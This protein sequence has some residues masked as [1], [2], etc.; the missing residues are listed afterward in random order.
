MRSSGIDFL[1]ITA[2]EEERDATLSVFPELRRL[3]A[4]QGDIRVYYSGRVLLPTGMDGSYRIVLVSLLDMGR[5]EAATATSDAIRRW[6][7]RYVILV[8]IAGGVFD[9]G[10]ALGDVL[11]PR[12]IVDYEH[13]KIQENS[14]PEVRFRTYT[15]DQRLIGS[16]QAL[17]ATE[18]TDRTSETPRPGLGESKR[19]IG[20]VACGDKVVAKE[21]FLKQSLNGWHRL[22]GV[23]MESSGVAVACMQ[24]AENPGFLM[25]KGVSDL[26]NADKSTSET[27]AW[28]EYACT[29]APHFLRALL[30]SCP[31]PTEP[32]TEV[33]DSNDGGWTIPDEALARVP[34]RIECLFGRK[35]QLEALDREVDSGKRQIAWIGP[36]G[37]GKSSLVRWWLGRRKWRAKYRL[38]AHSFYSQGSRNQGISSRLLLEEWLGE[39]GVETSTDQKDFTLGAEFASKLAG[40]PTI[41]ILD[42][43]EPIQLGGAD[44]ALR[45]NLIDPGIQGLLTTLA[46]HPG[47]NI[48][49]IT[50]RESLTDP[51][52]RESPVFAELSLPPLT[53]EGARELLRH[54]GISGDDIELD[55][56]SRSCSHHAFALTLAAA[57]I[58]TFAMRKAGRF[59]ASQWSL[60]AD[61]E[62]AQNI[63]AWFDGALAQTNEKLMR[64]LLRIL[65]LFDRP[66]GWDALMA[67]RDGYGMDGLNNRLK[68]AGAHE[69]VSA[70]ARLR[71]WHLMHVDLTE[72]EPD[73]DAHPIVREFFGERLKQ[74][75]LDAYRSAHQR[76]WSHFI[77]ISVP[78]P[79]SIRDMGTFIHAIAH[80]CKGRDPATVYFETYHRRMTNNRRSHLRQQL[81]AYT[82]L[83]S[84]LSNFFPNGFLAPME[85][86]PIPPFSRGMLCSD[87]SLLLANLGRL[88]EAIRMKEAAIEFYKGEKKV[89]DMV[90]ARCELV[91]YKVDQGSDL[92]GTHKLS[93]DTLRLSREVPEMG[94]LPTKMDCVLN[95]LW[96]LAYLQYTTG[97]I[98]ESLDIFHL[99]EQMHFEHT[100]E[101]VLISKAGFNYC[102][103]LLDTARTDDDLE[104]VAQRAM[105]MNAVAQENRWADELALGYSIMG[106]AYARKGEFPVSKAFMERAVRCAEESKVDEIRPHVHLA[107]ARVWHGAGYHE[108]ALKELHKA[109]RLARRMAMR[110]LVADCHLLNCTIQLDSEESHPLLAAEKAYIE[111]N[112]I[113]S[114][115]GYNLRQCERL[116]ALARI[117][118]VRGM[119]QEAMK[120]FWECLGVFK[121]R[122][123][124]SL[125]AGLLKVSSSLGVELDLS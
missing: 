91:C 35:G 20:N 108:L 111:A 60:D 76:L 117:Q 82:S 95:A 96:G 68:E 1:F 94:S 81:G 107:F 112:T 59:L 42:G 99:S 6:S 67:L 25:I 49:L 120:T 65:G 87:V 69:I 33:G 92:F 43:L 89:G 123:L 101:T 63:L 66:F 10:V 17:R 34:G 11:V 3:P 24:A 83:L 57:F 84:V 7:P 41:L 2:L 36:G 26:A 16:V 122:S 48:C 77:D 15:V 71:Q 53:N 45:G 23:D 14:V 90:I 27:V 8:G 9:E 51:D 13:Q 98:K 103:L 37:M 104:M 29:I 50:S 32:E 5:V 118:L 86:F 80:G 124:Y 61:R 54:Q 70:V 115:S 46:D 106:Q 4:E 19:H 78:T 64:E 21:A 97:V 12:Q 72:E 113:I 52:I 88:S 44:E 102:R 55:Q 56:I 79:Y 93:T 38:F 18:W 110:P 58:Y 31:V 109:F 47:D 75:N 100:K 40:E 28:R 73:I 39:Y 105:T 125:E 74:E 22:I 116:L 114:G 85:C 121:G 119:C 62:P 30:M